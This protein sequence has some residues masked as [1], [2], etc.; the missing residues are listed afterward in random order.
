MLLTVNLFLCSAPISK[1]IGYLPPGIPRILINR[2]IVHPAHE[3]DED[4]DREK[5]FRTNYTFDSYLLGFCDDVARILAK[6]LFT[7]EVESY[8][9][10]KLLASL[11]EKDEHYKAEDW[12][13]CTVPQQRIFLF[14]GAQAPCND[15]E[16]VLTYREVAQCDGCSERIAGT[17]R[18]CIS[19]FDYDLCSSCYPELS[20]THGDGKHQFLEETAVEDVRPQGKQN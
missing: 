20:K 5:D 12:R 13:S 18:K 14:P 17:I 9:D 2:T 6:Q 4:D 11:E 16:S 7:S 15:D 19:C 10:G 3:H 8:T 1:V